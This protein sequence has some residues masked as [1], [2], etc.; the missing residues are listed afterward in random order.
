MFLR[1]RP[2]E[3]E[4]LQMQP[5]ILVWRGG[6]AQRKFQNKADSVCTTL[7]QHW[8]RVPERKQ[9]GLP[10]RVK[11][12]IQKVVRNT[13]YV[14]WNS[15]WCPWRIYRKFYLTKIIWPPNTLLN[16]FN[17]GVCIHSIHRNSVR[18]FIYLLIKYVCVLPSGLLW[19][20]YMPVCGD[21]NQTGCCALRIPLYM[22]NKT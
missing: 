21:S 5:P 8:T 10:Q 11:I 16:S 14:A 18:L 13:S 1:L 19:D 15:I 17:H 9:Y 6:S 3:V 20:S 4:F 22:K 7:S 12:Y 2:T